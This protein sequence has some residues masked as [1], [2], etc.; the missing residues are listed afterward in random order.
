MTEKTST[1]DIPVHPVRP[2]VAA[3]DYHLTEG[4]TLADLRRRSGR[5]RRARPSSSTASPPMRHGSRATA[6]S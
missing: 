3:R 2:G 4:A 6:R 1:A 5:R